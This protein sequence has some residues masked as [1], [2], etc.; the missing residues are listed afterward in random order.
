MQDEQIGELLENM[1][2]AIKTIAEILQDLS[3]RVL[4]LENER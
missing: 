3:D 1:S 2:S 4:R